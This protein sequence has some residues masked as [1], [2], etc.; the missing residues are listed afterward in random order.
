LYRILEAAPFSDV[1]N[2][3]KH[4]G[5][6]VVMSNQSLGNVLAH[7]I[8]HSLQLPHVVGQHNHLNLM[9]S[10]ADSSCPQD[11]HQLGSELTVDQWQK[12]VKAAQEWK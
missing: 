7:G 3:C 1:P 2:S 5:N 11:A 4:F 12:A 9:C 6:I 8:G 10:A